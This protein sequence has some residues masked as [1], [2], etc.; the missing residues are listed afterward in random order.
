MGEGHKTGP[1]SVRVMSHVSLQPTRLG[2]D[3]HWLPMVFRVPGRLKSDT[4]QRGWCGLYQVARTWRSGGKTGGQE[5]ARGGGH[6]LSLG[7]DQSVFHLFH[8]T[9]PIASAGSVLKMTYS[10]RSSGACD[11]LMLVQF[12]RWPALVG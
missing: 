11:H 3:C 7:V 5:N 1:V 12:D 6:D 2:G 10:L 4:S 8:S 9:A